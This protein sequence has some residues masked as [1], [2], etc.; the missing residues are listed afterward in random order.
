LLF[1]KDSKIYAQ[2]R[3]YKIIS[4]LQENYKNDSTFQIFANSVMVKLGNFPALTLLEKENQEELRQPY[5]TLLTRSVKETY[6]EIPDSEYTFTDP[7]YKIFESLKNNNHY[8]FS[9][10]T[11]LGKSFIINAFIRYLIKEHRRTDNIVILVPS[12]A[13]INQTVIKLKEEFK[14]EEKY[15]ILAK[16][17]RYRVFLGKS[18][19]Q[20]L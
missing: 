3:A 19:L 11:S 5:E 14:K 4:L 6:Q 17:I 8:S 16:Y 13:L 20:I 18:L 15:T 12:R 1:F 10:P 9:G 2:N 7:Q